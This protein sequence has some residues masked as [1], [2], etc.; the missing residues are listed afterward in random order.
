MVT[1]SYFEESQRKK[2]PFAVIESRFL[3]HDLI[4]ITSRKSSTKII[5]FY[6]RIPYFSDYSP[7]MLEHN[8]VEQLDM[9]PPTKYPFAFKRSNYKE[10]SISFEFGNEEEA[11]A[12]INQVSQ[13]YKK[14]KKKAA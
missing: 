9:K 13:L 2:Q 4:K 8:V 14:L 12:C 6:F 11:K 10:V 3:M 7:E 5:T 1:F